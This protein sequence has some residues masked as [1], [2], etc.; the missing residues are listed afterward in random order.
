M[1]DRYVIPLWRIACAACGKDPDFSP[2]GL[3]ERISRNRQPAMAK[4]D[5]LK[6]V[7]K[8]HH[9]SDQE[10]TNNFMDSMDKARIML[11]LLPAHCLDKLQVARN[12]QPFF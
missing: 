7:L 12:G 5:G 8:T 6:P 10:V 11:T 3:I 1:L 2:T 9:V 4:R